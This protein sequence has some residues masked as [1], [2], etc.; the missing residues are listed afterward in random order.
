M[1]T[2][3]VFCGVMFGCAAVANA[4]TLVPG[5]NQMLTYTAAVNDQLTIGISETLIQ[6]VGTLYS[7]GPEVN[8]I[9]VRLTSIGGTY[10]LDGDEYPIPSTTQIEN[11]AGQWT[12]PG[13][14][15]YLPST[16][17]NGSTALNPAG[18]DGLC[19]DA[20]YP[21]YWSGGGRSVV[22]LDSTAPGPGFAATGSGVGNN[23]YTF[24]ATAINGGWYTPNSAY[25]I[26][27]TPAYY[28]GATF[29]NQMLASFYVS[30]STQYVQFYTTD[31]QPWNVIGYPQMGDYGQMGFNY[32]NGG[33]T[34]YVEI[35]AIPHSNLVTNGGF[36]T[37]DFSG[38]TTVAASYGSAFGVYPSAG[39]IAP[40]SGNH[41]AGF[42]SWGRIDDTILQ[43]AGNH[44]GRV[45]Y[46]HF[47]VSAR[48]HGQ[49]QRLYRELER[50]AD[51]CVAER[52]RVRLDGI[53]VY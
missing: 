49:R 39:L 10:Q 35:T 19:G 42:G 41:Y 53:H 40:H 46:V 27:T 2:L 4:F 17:A 23:A 25:R 29:D 3:S 14:V 12:F 45:V 51:S 43:V 37:N 11:I 31:G 44:S 6:N 20:D 15:A 28:P 5:A 18:F 48:Q 22:N 8:E 30:P 52:R 50:R 34:D 7:G 21:G 33:R 36:E 32:S 9:D 1:K 26:A 47:L 13:G 24:A 38:W 16:R